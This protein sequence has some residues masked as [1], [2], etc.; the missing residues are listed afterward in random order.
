MQLVIPYWGTAESPLDAK[1]G[2]LDVLQ[3]HPARPLASEQPTGRPD[4]IIVAGREPEGSKRVPPEVCGDHQPRGLR[5][6]GRCAGQPQPGDVAGA[7][8]LGWVPDHNVCGVPL[9]GG[10]Q[11]KVDSDPSDRGRWLPGGVAEHL[12]HH[13]GTGE[14]LTCA[15]QEPHPDDAPTSIANACDRLIERDRGGTMN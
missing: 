15:N 10:D 12:L 2:L 11:R 9:S 4:A 14:N 13:M 5:T 6:L 7:V 8:G 1:A 3:L